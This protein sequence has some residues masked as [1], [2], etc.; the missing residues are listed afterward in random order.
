[1]RGVRAFGFLPPFKPGEGESFVALYC[2]RFQ[3][4]CAAD[5]A[6]KN[7]PAF[8]AGGW[9]VL[10]DALSGDQGNKP[11]RGPSK[12]NMSNRSE[13]AGLFIGT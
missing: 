11:P 2:R 12:S 10:S 9:L 6:N 7:P 4:G 13:I 8:L 3:A 1:M 5:G